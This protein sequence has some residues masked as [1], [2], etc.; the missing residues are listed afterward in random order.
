[1]V[2]FV[3]ILHIIVALLLITI[4]LMQDS[5]GGGMGGAFGGGN[6]NSVFGATGTANIFVKITR[7]LVFLFA[8]TCILLTRFYSQKTESVLDRVNSPAASSQPAP[9]TVPAP[10][11]ET[12]PATPPSP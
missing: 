11:A 12:A 6:A 4:V 7:G 5:K 10:A 3:A 8:V 9:S 2:G 1:M